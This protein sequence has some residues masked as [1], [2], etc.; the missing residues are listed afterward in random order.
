MDTWDFIKDQ[1]DGHAVGVIT[2]KTPRANYQY[3]LNGKEWQDELGLNMYAMDMR[4]YDPAI[5]RWIVQDPV[6]HHN[7]SPYNAFD[8]NPVFWADPSGGN[9]ETPQVDMFGRPKYDS[10]GMY[11]PPFERGSDALTSNDGGTSYLGGGGPSN[12]NNIHLEG[13]AA[14]VFVTLLQK[15]LNSRL[16]DLMQKTILEIVYQRTN[17]TKNSTTGFFYIEGTDITGYFIEPSGPST[18]KSKLDKRI[19]ADNYFLKLNQGKKYGLLVYNNK[20][21]ESRGIVIHIGNYPIDT[22][23]CLLPGKTIGVDFVGNS[24]AALEAIMAAYNTITTEFAELRLRIIDIK[25]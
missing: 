13:E 22:V 2:A 4:Q 11:I 16:N 24:G 23:G 14:Q 19:P 17:E 7:F 3:K 21:P 25:R 5:A 10:N 1:A 9:S 20:V 6:I 12:S 18:T 15:F 8:N